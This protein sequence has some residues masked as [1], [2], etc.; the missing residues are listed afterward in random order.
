VKGIQKWQTPPDWG[1]KEIL[2]ENQKLYIPSELE[3]MFVLSGFRDV[4][5]CG[6]EP[7]NFKGQALQADDIELMVIGVKTGL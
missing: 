7:G 3:M 5:I 4:R 6:C 1:G 2:Q